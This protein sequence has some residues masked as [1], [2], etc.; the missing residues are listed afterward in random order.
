MR[1]RLVALFA[2]S[3]L[4]LV[5][6]SAAPTRPELLENDWPECAPHGGPAAVTPT[7][8]DVY[9]KKERRKTRV[10]RELRS[11]NKVR[12]VRG[13]AEI[14]LELKRT[15]CHPVGTTTVWVQ[16][17]PSVLVSFRR[18]TLGC[19][20]AN[21]K[22]GAKV[23]T[24]AGVGLKFADPLFVVALRHKTTFV[25]VISGLIE[26]TA[27]GH[28]VVVG[29]GKQTSVQAG[30]TPAQPTKL[31]LD[32][33]E[34]KATATLRSQVPKPRFQPPSAVGSP[35]LK[36]IYGPRQMRVAV[37]NRSTNDTERPLTFA[38]KVFGLLSAKWGLSQSPPTQA[39]PVDGLGEL[40]AHDIHVFVTP[41]AAT[42][43]AAG[44]Q[45]P[46]FVDGFGNE[47]YVLGNRDPVFFAALRSFLLQTIQGL[48]PIYG[49]FYRSVFAPKPPDYSIFDPL[50]T[51]G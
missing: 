11:G 38:G 42:A 20:D 1:L 12:T 25:Q 27:H 43:K 34:T 35:T 46:L 49:V 47:W 36:D 22:K 8:Q 48:P 45:L 17:S 10:K 51:P 6:V 18:G 4:A 2:V 32:G 30:G 5:A 16:P 13:S 23:R 15:I 21:L 33:L 41:D 26:V 7:L 9:V 3:A 29:P 31:E 28:S 24:K 39:S 44:W 50:I 40:R 37:D 14:C 19:V